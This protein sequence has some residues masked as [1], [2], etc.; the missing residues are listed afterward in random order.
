[1]K[2]LLPILALAGLGVFLARP[3]RSQDPWEPT[4]LD[5]LADLIDRTD[6]FLTGTRSPR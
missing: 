6:F 5:H 2:R 3:R 4:V 1:M